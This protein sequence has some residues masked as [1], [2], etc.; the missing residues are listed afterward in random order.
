MSKKSFE[1]PRDFDNIPKN[2]D[3]P[4]YP[5]KEKNFDIPDIPDDES[6]Y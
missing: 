3:I 2:F 6:I 4:G 5:L 1:I